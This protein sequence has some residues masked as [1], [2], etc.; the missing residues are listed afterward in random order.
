MTKPFQLTPKR[1]VYLDVKDYLTDPAYV[2]DPAQKA[3]FEKLDVIYRAMTALLYNYVPLSGHVGGSVS[4]GRFVS[5]LIYNVLA[6]ELAAPHRLEAD[7]ISYAAGHKA[8]GLY[9]AWALRNECARA[10][11]PELLAKDIKEQL[12]LEDLLGFRRNG[13]Q[14]TPLFN[15]FHAKPLGG[16][17]EPLV[18]F[19]RTSTGASGVGDGSAVGLGFGAADAYGANCPRVHIVEG[20]GGLTAGR[21]AEAIAAAA[22]AQLKNVVFHLDWNEASIESN[23]VTADGRTPGDYVQWTPAELFYIND[24]NVI[25]VPDGL[26]FAQI[27]AAHKLLER[28]DNH[29]PTAVVY[30]TVKG[31]KYGLEGKASHGSGHKFC[32][33]AFYDFLGEFERTF[34]LSFPRFAG[35]QTPEN[36]ERYYWDS[37]LLVRRAL[38]NDAQLA[39]F[40]A[41]RVAERKTALDG[42]KRVRRAGLGNVEDLYTKFAPEAVPA[43]F[44]FTPGE[45]Y[46]SRAVLGDV[47]GYLN[48]QTGGTILAASAD[49]YGSTNAGNIAAG[50]EKGF[51]N[52]KSNPLSRKLSVG[53]ICEDGMAAVCSGV[54]SF[55]AH[56]GVS[57]SYG[58]FLAF[59]H[60]AARLHAIG[61]QTGREAGLAPNTLVLFNSHASLP[62]GEDGPTHADPQALQLVQDNFPKGACITA[63]PLL[64]DEIW[65]LVTRALQLRPAVF[66]PFVVRPGGKLP[67]RVAL[68]IEPALNASKGVYYLMRADASL[69]DD[70]AVIVQGAGI[71]TDFVNAVLPELKKTGLNL[72]VIYVSSRELFESLPP[73][74]Q[75]ELVP[76]ALRKRAMGVTDFTLPTMDCWLLSDLGRRHTVFPH[77]SGKYLASA[78]AAKVYEEAGMASGDILK[79]VIGYAAEL[80]QAAAAR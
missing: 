53:G 61:C 78:N 76:V 12:R 32:S 8:L 23:E 22:T 34:N 20:E 44:A 72:N 30:R 65:P 15:E 17:P 27:H 57:A 38:Q 52:A 25:F 10:A 47:L 55:G 48:E 35:E 80:K 69:P 42:L 71:G 29:Q 46:T 59:A 40:F 64:A 6:Y 66:C 28:M 19:V 50:F 67:N 60:V 26:D 16:H 56:V 37:L 2:L 14:G 9:A 5:H 31:W 73:S 54:S 49:L 75:E 63:T 13:V 1:A 21:A 39:G 4:S 58:A 62:T 68:G 41:A 43:R 3:C 11:K 77:K 18:P 79:A 33:D 51:F 74:E 70:G 24:F 36:I 45:N 7:I